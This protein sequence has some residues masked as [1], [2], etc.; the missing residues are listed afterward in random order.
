MATITR[1]NIAPLN[2]KLT[3][4]ISKEDYLPTVEKSIKNYAKTATIQGF[5]KGMVPSGLVKKMY[6]QSILN[7]E[8]IK[9][10]D[11]ELN[12]YISDE[13]IAILAQP[14][15]LEQKDLQLDINN[16]QDYDFNFEIGLQPE[17]ELDPKKIKTTRYQVE[18]KD[19]MVEEEVDR[20]RSRF[21]EY[22]SPETIEDEDTIISSTIELA[23]EDA[24]ATKEKAAKEVAE[25]TE[26]EGQ[27]A[28]E[29]EKKEKDT[30]VNLKDIAKTQQKE[31]KGKK[32][33]DSV[34]VQLDKAFKGDILER[35]LTDLGLDK[36]VKANGKKTATL[37]I[38]KLGLLEKPAMDE[39]LFEKVYPGKEIKTED[40]FK[41]AIKE[42]LGKYYGGQAS[43]QIHDQIYHHLTD[44][45]QLDMPEAFLK[46]W[47]LVSKEGKITEAEVDKEYPTF[48]KQLQWALIS[49]K[50]SNDN[51]VKVENQEIKDFA[52]Q[53]LMGYLGGQ[54]GLT[55]DEPWVDE[56]INK[57]LADQK[58]MEDAYGQIRIGKLFEILETQVTAEDKAISEE[59][60]A[61]LLKQ[62]QHDHEQ[63]GHDHDHE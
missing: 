11:A 22:Q 7:D 9:K 62:H 2:D 31:F 32:V 21:G 61:A 54:M 56:Y 40:A 19:K 4:K 12:K 53:Q 45:I 39:A 25:A 57:M 26:T 41:A 10:V 15:A 1:E 51:D 48:T 33:G 46:R 42:D 13:K 20:L 16:P 18:I 30:A 29:E 8:V 3:V 36:S 43:S 52:R 55:G 34:T 23:D 58:F 59:D 17:V 38:T 60:F 50:L 63:E 28:G 27:E 44:D 5:R 49:S 47:M 35:V 24:A 6:G 14:I 37:T